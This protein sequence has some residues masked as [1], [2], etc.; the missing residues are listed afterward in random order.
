MVFA[1]EGLGQHKDKD[2]GGSGTHRARTVHLFYLDNLLDPVVFLCCCPVRC[3]VAE[4]VPQ[5]TLYAM[6]TALCMLSLGLLLISTMS[7]SW[8]RAGTHVF[9][10]RSSANERVPATILSPLQCPGDYLCTQYEVHAKAVIHDTVALHRLGF[11][12]R[13][14]PSLSASSK[15]ESDRAPLDEQ[16]LYINPFAVYNPD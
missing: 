1:S 16:L 9:Y 4:L 15:S 5:F 10:N 13:S 12:I 8:V 3:R 2:N 14:P 7:L 6:R 11:H